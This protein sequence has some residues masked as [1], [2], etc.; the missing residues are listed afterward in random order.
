[1]FDY[2]RLRTELQ[3]GKIPL[4]ITKGKGSLQ[5]KNLPLEGFLP[6]EKF[7]RYELFR[8]GGAVK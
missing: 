7:D 6:P 5:L 4:I 3:Q 8:F 1:V 2:T